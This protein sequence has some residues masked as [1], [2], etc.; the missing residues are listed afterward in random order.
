M[1]DQFKV[2]YPA[3]GAGY[4]LSK[5]NKDQYLQFRHVFVNQC[6]YHSVWQKNKDQAAIQSILN[7]ICMIICKRIPEGVVAFNT[8]DL[9]KKIKLV[10][11]PRGMGFEQI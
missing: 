6:M 7:V 10:P 5:L 1:C 11:L 9:S 3:A 2:A 8:A 4:D